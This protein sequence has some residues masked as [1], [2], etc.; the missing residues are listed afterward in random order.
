LYLSYNFSCKSVIYVLFFLIFI[1]S[2]MTAIFRAASSGD[3]SHQAPPRGDTG[4]AAEILVAMT[5][6]TAR[7]PASLAMSD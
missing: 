3:C 2:F 4:E 5:Q 6:S 1:Y 7:L